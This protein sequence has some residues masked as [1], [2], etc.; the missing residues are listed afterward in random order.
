MSERTQA[1]RACGMSGTAAWRTI[2]TL[3]PLTLLSHVETASAGI[4]SP[5]MTFYVAQVSG[6]PAWEEV[7]I[8]PMFSD[9]VDSYVA[10]AALSGT[11]AR[12]RDNR[13]HLE[14]EGQIAYNFG[15]QDHWEFNA[16]PVMGRWRW[17]PWQQSLATSAAFGLGLSYATDRPEVEVAL[18]GESH[19]LLV[20]WVAELTA[21][22]S[23]APWSVSLRLHHRSVAYGL[24]GKDG[25]MNGIGLGMRYGF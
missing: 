5:V 1:R 6:E 25:G 23:R 4:D 9:Y 7:F 17:F 2:I 22:P 21:G 8:N 24:F 19:R 10:V 20:Y 16:V 3:L 18:E 15:G 14:A 13:L 12:Y 11:Y